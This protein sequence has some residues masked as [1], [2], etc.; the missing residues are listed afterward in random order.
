MQLSLMAEQK[1]ALPYDPELVRRAINAPVLAVDIETQTTNEFSSLKEFGLSFLAPVTFVSLAF[2]DGE[3]IRSVV[4]SAP[5]DEKVQY[6]LDC[7]M[8]RELV[9]V[10]HNGTFDCR[11]L[12]KFSKGRVPLH[13]WDT[14]IMARLIHPELQ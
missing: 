10:F 12:S 7:I 8:R 4:F 9:T 14:M 3:D 5:F 11:G 1:T 2:M 13:I 6:Y